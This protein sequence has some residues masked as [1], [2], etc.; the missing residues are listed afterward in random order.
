LQTVPTAKNDVET[1]KSSPIKASPKVE[2]GIIVTPTTPHLF[3]SKLTDIIISF[4]VDE[5]DIKRR[6][7]IIYDEEEEEEPI[8]PTKNT[9]NKTPNKASTSSS[10][11]PTSNKSTPAK[12]ASASKPAAK[13]ARTEESEDEWD[14]LDSEVSVSGASLNDDDSFVVEGS[15]ES[16]GES[17]DELVDSDASEEEE[18]SRKKRP[19]SKPPLPPK[20]TNSATKSKPDASNTTTPA[21]SRVLIPFDSAA[22]TPNSLNAFKQSNAQISPHSRGGSPFFGTPGTPN[23]TTSNN[24]NSAASTPTGS[25][26]QVLNLPEGV[27]GRGSHE[28]NQ[29]AFL[30][31]ENRRD[32][33]GVKYGEPGYNAR[34]LTVPSKFLSEQT[35]AMA[36]WWQFKAAN[37]DTVLF[38][39][40]MSIVS[41]SVTVICS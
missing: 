15:E 33:A 36:Q 39:K 7:T 18:T 2:K 13:K 24:T 26:G 41:V 3:V 11:T 35:P 38:F 32:G 31:P 10:K 16:S 4:F 17:D 29:F 6:K 5:G 27:V 22:K 12:P 21:K 30:Y 28:H 40:V 20:T 19:R 8:K 34:T 1:V 37:M 14:G 23:S 9:P 25:N